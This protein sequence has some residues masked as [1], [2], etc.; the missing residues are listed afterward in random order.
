MILLKTVYI[1]PKKE[2]TKRRSKRIAK[3]LYKISKKED[4]VVALSKNLRKQEDLK[5]EIMEY[6]IKILNGRWLFKFLLCDVLEFICK[7]ENRRIETINIAFLINSNDDIIIAQIIR[8]AKMV[9]NVRII[10]QNISRFSYLENLLYEK[11]GIAIQV[12][13][14]KLKSLNNI[15]IIINYDFKY[16][17]IKEYNIGCF[18]TI[19]NI[20]QELEKVKNNFEGN[21]INYYE[22]EYNKENYADMENDLCFEPNILYESYIYRRDTYSNIYDK[23]MAD[24]VKIVNLL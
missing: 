14:N 10:S 24:N 6:G 12:T 9:K 13:N 15:D 5:N 4:I 23:L 11:Y 16:D 21:N 8:I 1:N 19:V 20:K 17:V 3:K 7:K 18:A 2:V 22:I